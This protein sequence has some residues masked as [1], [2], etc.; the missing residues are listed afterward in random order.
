MEPSRNNEPMQDTDPLRELIAFFEQNIMSIMHINDPKKMI[1]TIQKDT[2]AEAAKA[3]ETAKVLRDLSIERKGQKL[4][5]PE[6]VEYG[7]AIQALTLK[8]EEEEQ[9]VAVNYTTNGDVAEGMVAFL[10]VL[11][12]EFGFVSN[13]GKE[14]F[15]GKSPPAFIAIETSP[16]KKETIPV[17][18]LK[19]PGI[20]GY[21]SP[22]FEPQ[23]NRV[24]FK[25]SGM[26]KGKDRL[27]VD[28]IF[29]KVQEECKRNSIYRGHAITTAFPTIEEC[30]SLA[31]TFP[32]FSNLSRV[33]PEEVVFSQEIADQIM[34]SLYMPIKKTQRCRENNIPLKRGVLLEGPY[35]VGKTL[36]AAVTATIC[37]D[38][39]WT[40][41]YLKDVSRLAQ[42]YAFAEQYQPAVIFAEDI[43][44]ILVDQDARD[45]EINS[46]LNALD[47]ID[48]K[49]IEVITVLTTNHV[50]KMTR[51][52][53]RPGRLDTVVSVQP[54]DKEAA[55]K[56]VRLYGGDLID[57]NSDLSAV[58]DL[59]AGEIPA[60]IREVVDRSKLAALRRDGEFKIESRDIEVTA[61][62]M[63]SHMALLKPKDPDTR[64]DRVK[65]A[66]IM[67]DASIKSATIKASTFKE[68]EAA[69]IKP[70]SN[71]AA[72]VNQ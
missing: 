7:I 70:K 65:A 49:G 46:I 25:I 3:E 12:S 2:K 54:P 61:K 47:G 43:D 20:T 29:E 5:V 23:D 24:V 21:L 15:F 40:F 55:I 68:E 27:K 39:G 33:E 60:L 17:G 1:M 42:A 11:Q 57:P 9:E 13:T 71:G 59:L 22:G 31:D 8:M 53:L 38:N 30:M 63:K 69:A 66:Q 35:G 16:G 28:R 51:A 41:I 14:S 56:L 62:S 36:T 58:G 6:D 45:E 48:S 18:N 34:V 19:I 37:K 52:M 26:V 72:V 10:R 4:I 50:E 67:A 32:K 64:S 44:Q